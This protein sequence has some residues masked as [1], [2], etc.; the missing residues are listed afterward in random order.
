MKKLLMAIVIVLIA[1]PLVVG[2]TEE[3]YNPDGVRWDHNTE[4]DLAG[5][6]IYETTTSGSYEGLTFAFSVPAGTNQWE[7]ETDH[8][9]GKFYWSAT[10]YDFAGNES[11]LSNEAEATFDHTPPDAP[12]GCMTFRNP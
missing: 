4:P 10:A 5:Y 7:F 3:V 11:G 2:Q 8:P 9:E 6:Y 1:S 12:T